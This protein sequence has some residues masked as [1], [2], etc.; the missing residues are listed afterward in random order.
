LGG[1]RLQACRKAQHD[2]SF[3]SGHEFSRAGQVL[4]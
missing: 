4:T 3:V 1:A 2:V